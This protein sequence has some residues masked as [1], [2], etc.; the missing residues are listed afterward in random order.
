METRAP[1][2]RRTSRWRAAAVFFRRAFVASCLLN[3]L[4]LA[5][6][7]RGLLS[8]NMARAILIDG[9]LVCLVRSEKAANQAREAIIAAAK[10][11]YEGEAS[12]KQNWEDKPWP[13]KAEKVCTNDEAV[14]LLAPKLDVVVTAFAI[15]VKGRDI[16][17]VPSQ[18][19]AEEVLR[20]VKA[21]FLSEGETPLEPQTF[22][23]EP[24]IAQVQVP[25]DAALTDI[26]TA[27]EE[28]LRGT[29]EPQ[30]Y[31]VKTGDYPESVAKANSMTV[32]QLYRLNPGLKEKAN[33]NDIHPGDEWTVA[34]PRPRLVVITKKETTR[35]V[36]VGFDVVTK[37]TASM[38]KGE[39]RVPREGKEGQ[40]KEWIRATWRNDHIVP[41]SVKVT[42]KEIIEEPEAKVILKGTGPAASAG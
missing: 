34:G 21:E 42:R 19:T 35:T 41:E 15:Q 26:H 33:S 2:D 17:A 8:R 4:L 40:K 25:P 28:L 9:E 11:D 7:V 39:V 16:L 24:V 12:L 1:E 31:V 18:E 14:E 22:E 29:T 13:A 6:V 10:G 32:D 5:I 3:I 36:P 37:P 20:T 27:T 38:P 23:V 30:K